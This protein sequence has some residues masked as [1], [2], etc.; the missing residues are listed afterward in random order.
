MKK[1]IMTFS[2]FL[3]FVSSVAM[4]DNGKINACGI[5]DKSKAEISNC[6]KTRYNGYMIDVV[7]SGCC[8]WHGGVCGCQYGRVVCCDGSYSPSCGCNHDELIKIIN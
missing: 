5:L 3:C 8:S 4:A 6:N 2:L 1:R 7:Q